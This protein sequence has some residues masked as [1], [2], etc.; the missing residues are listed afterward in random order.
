MAKGVSL[1]KILE[2]MTHQV[3]ILM[4]DK[5]VSTV[6]SVLETVLS[7]TDRDDD[8]YGSEVI[9]DILKKMGE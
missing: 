7:G 2:G 9:Q 8:W 1:K 4:T 5:E 3:L 6:K